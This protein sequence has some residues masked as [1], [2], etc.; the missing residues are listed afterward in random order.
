M[1]NM[2]PMGLVLFTV[3][4]IAG[5]SSVYGDYVDMP[6][7]VVSGSSEEIQ[8]Y[9]GSL[10]CDEQRLNI[11]HCGNEC[12]NRSQS[13]VGC[14]GFYMN[15]S[16]IGS[17]FICHVSSITEIQANNF[18]T[19]SDNTILFVLY[20]KTAEPRV[21]LNFDQYITE[22]GKLKV[23]GTNTEGATENVAETD[24]VPGKRD[25]GLHFHSGGDVYLSGSGTECWTNLDRCP[26]GLTISIWVKIETLKKSY[27][28]GTGAVQQKGVSLFFNK[29]GEVRTVVQLD[30]SRYDSFHNC[31]KHYSTYRFKF[32]HTILLSLPTK[33]C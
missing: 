14:T 12:F 30:S 15:S 4:C 18:T 2:F 22:A 3:M 19:F 9:N 11:E 23:P 29:D 25:L 17:C 6:Y 16:L 10:M 20:T 31:A 28:V 5:H 24:F 1:L 27:I 13:G 32:H 33:M 21:S 26:S 8:V 7:R